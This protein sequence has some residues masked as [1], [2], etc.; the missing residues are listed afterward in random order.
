MLIKLINKMHSTKQPSVPF[1]IISSVVQSPSK[2]LFALGFVFI[3]FNLVFSTKFLFHWFLRFFP[4]VSTE[5]KQM[6]NIFTKSMRLSRLAPEPNRLSDYKIWLFF[7]FIA[8][9][10]VVKFRFSIRFFIP[11]FFVSLMHVA[12]SF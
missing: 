10:T 9:D 12:F 3:S 8:F 11:C 4:N 5:N 2:L 7:W 1:A 6:C